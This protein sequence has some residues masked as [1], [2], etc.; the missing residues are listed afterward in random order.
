M[1]TNLLPVSSLVLFLLDA[2]VVKLTAEAAFT[3]DHS[4]T[5]DDYASVTADKS[6]VSAG[7]PAIYLFAAGLV[8]SPASGEWRKTTLSRPP[9]FRG[10]SR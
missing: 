8:P 10:L 4:Q 1:D 6:G 7:P 2:S 5:V 3:Y 9:G